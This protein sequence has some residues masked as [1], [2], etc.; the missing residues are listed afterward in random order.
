MSLAVDVI[1]DV[2]CPWCYIGKRRLEKA[3]AALDRPVKVRWLPFQLNPSMPKEGIS[4][5][6]YRTKKFGSWERSQELDARVIAVGQSEGIPFAFDRIERT[7]N[8]LDAHRLVGLAGSKGA[9]GAV[10]EALFR[11][12][13]TEGR[14]ISNRQPLLDIVAEAGLDR[15]EA[16]AV[17]NCDDGLEAIKEAEG[18]SQRHRVDGVPFFIINGKNTL[19]GAQ[20]P[21]AF[22]EAFRQAT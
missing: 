15:Q 6:E 18:L 4:R 20:Q 19:G 2:I 7:P 3:V 8:T 11:A 22:L 9:Q 1:S 10:V 5:R 17:L 12:Y 21:D 16:E 13:F 14:D